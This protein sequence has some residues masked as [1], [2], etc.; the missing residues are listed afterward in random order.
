MTATITT[1]GIAL[2]SAKGVVSRIA[3]TLAA[4]ITRAKARHDYRRLM[5]CDEIMRDVGLSRDE[6]RHALMELDGRG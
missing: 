3:A 6:V 5:E 2:P 4:A 1:A